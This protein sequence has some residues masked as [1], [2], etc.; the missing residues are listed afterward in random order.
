MHGPLGY[1]RLGRV[2][3]R[4]KLR[5]EY[6]KRKETFL[7]AVP[8]ANEIQGI[9]T[10]T[11]TSGMDNMAVLSIRQ[12]SV[13][14]LRA[15]VSQ[16]APA[17]VARITTSA[18]AGLTTITA[19]WQI[20]L[21]AIATL[22]NISSITATGGTDAFTFAVMLTNTCSLQASAKVVSVTC[23]T[24]YLCKPASRP[25]KCYKLVEI[26]GEKTKYYHSPSKAY[27]PGITRCVQKDFLGS[28]TYLP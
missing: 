8:E 16:T 18:I 26:R 17:Q 23:G 14:T 28:N 4:T 5:Q 7:V 9:A 12:P 25:K 22:G 1:H 21:N 6:S 2:Y 19:N 20:S 24:G 11:C 27:L 15:E 3:P 10:L 13:T